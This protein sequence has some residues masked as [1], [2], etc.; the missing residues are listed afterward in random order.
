MEDAKIDAIAREVLTSLKKTRGSSPGKSSVSPMPSDPP[1]RAATD[2]KPVLH[3]SLQLLSISGGVVG[4]PC[5]IEPDKPCV[6]SL[7]CRTFGH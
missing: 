4:S 2:A 3:A 7:R 6:G 1:S 5:I